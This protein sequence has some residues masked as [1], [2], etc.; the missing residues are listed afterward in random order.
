[1][2]IERRAALKIIAGSAAFAGMQ[3][4]PTRATAQQYPE[5]PV[6]IIVPFPAGGPYDLVTRAVANKVNARHGWTIVT[7][8]RG[9]ASGA[10]G[11][12]AAKQAQPDGYTLAT[13]NA[14]THGATPAVKRT[15]GYDPIKDL[16]PIVLLADASL[17][18]LVRDDLPARTVPDLVKLLRDKPGQL[19]YS[20]GGFGSQHHLGALMF[21]VRAG[22][23]Q[24]AAVHVPFQGL[25]PA[26]TA[27]IAGN[28]QFMITTTGAATQHIASGKLRPLAATGLRRSPRLPN[29]P[30]MQ[31]LGFQGFEVTVW[32]GFGAPA[33]TPDAVLA[34]WNEVA[35]EALADPDVR[36]Q[37][38]GFDYDARGG[39]AAEFAEFVA[40]DVARW[41]KLAEDTGLV[42]E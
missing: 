30:T 26:L 20:S 10:I 31:E 42:P 7:D 29:V 27:L 17:V 11:I 13:L 18:L 3:A 14:G 12:V 36:K 16:T 34:R 6:R 15:L 1:V 32:C 2:P 8:N 33:G 24:T 21:L 23:P 4:L 40:R 25:V 9:G 22:L 38:T 28:V 41:K 5:R 19:N 39:T 37:I 35:N